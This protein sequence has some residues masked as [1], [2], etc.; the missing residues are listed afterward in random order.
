MLICAVNSIRTQ[1][2]NNYIIALLTIAHVLG[3]SYHE[4]IVPGTHTHEDRFRGPCNFSRIVTSHE[5][6][7]DTLDRLLVGQ[8][9]ASTDR[10]LTIFF[11]CLF[12]KRW[13]RKRK[14]RHNNQTSN[15]QAT[16]W[17]KPTTQA[18]RTTR[19]TFFFGRTAV[20]AT[21]YLYYPFLRA[22]WIGVVCTITWLCCMWVSEMRASSGR[23][24][25]PC[26]Q[27]FV[28]LLPVHLYTPAS[29]LY[30]PLL[31]RQ[32]IRTQKKLSKS[33]AFRYKKNGCRIGLLINTRY[34]DT[35]ASWVCM[36]FIRPDICFTSPIFPDS[37]SIRE[38]R[39][40]MKIFHVCVRT[41]NI[42]GLDFCCVL[43]HPLLML[44]QQ[45]NELEIIF[46]GTSCIRILVA[47]SKYYSWWFLILRT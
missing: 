10:M 39:L 4:H 11:V 9:R 24:S 21:L 7:T 13:L 32:G 17:N 27:R 3:V 2:Q 38:S 34:T 23:S 25:L 22:L 1:S 33:E 29:A 46:A 35:Y 14:N 28:R 26:F 43:W 37:Y 20:L 12:V 40:C 47:D 19:I 8:T 15:S 16:R 36:I 44:L 45:S 31:S 30:V 18:S 5:W 6:K 42:S 41:Q